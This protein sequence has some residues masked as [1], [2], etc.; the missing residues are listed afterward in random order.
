[1][2]VYVCAYVCVC[3]CLYVRDFF[4]PSS[5][6]YFLMIGLSPQLLGVAPKKAI[7]LTA[8]HRVCART[9]WRVHVHTEAKHA[10]LVLHC[11][12]MWGILKLCEDRGH[13]R[14]SR[15]L[16]G[17]CE[18]LTQTRAACT[19][20]R[21]RACV[22]RPGDYAGGHKHTHTHTH[23]RTCARRVIDIGCYSRAPS[24]PPICYLHPSHYRVDR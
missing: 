3:V 9:P 18:I 24:P 23:A 21:V 17:S 19:P 13:S 14:G 6:H 16:D 8:S 4:P 2:C 11:S 12:H 5:S 15:F 22:R 20:A 7:K 1:M 10:Q